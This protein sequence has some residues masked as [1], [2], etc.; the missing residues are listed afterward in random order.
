MEALPVSLY[1][2]R[3][4]DE[5]EEYAQSGIPTALHMIYLLKCRVRLLEWR[6]HFAF[7]KH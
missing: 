6:V 1:R 5:L 7:A 3:F 2:D 4:M